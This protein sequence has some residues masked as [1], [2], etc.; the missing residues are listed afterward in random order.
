MRICTFDSHTHSFFSSDGNCSVENL[1]LTAEQKGL[2][3]FALTDHFECD[4]EGRS[5][6]S[7]RKSVESA[8]E[9][10]DKFKGRLIV[11]TGIELGQPIYALGEAEAALSCCDYDFVLASLHNIRGEP[12]FYYTDFSDKDTTHETLE[13]FFKEY[14]ELANWNRFDSVAHITYPFRYMIRTYN[15]RPSLK[16]YMGYVDEFLKVIIQNGKGIEINTS[17]L[18]QGL[19]ITMPELDC[20]KRFRELGGEI[21]TVGS[22]AHKASD[23]GAD[24]S[25]ATEMLK[26]AGF[27]RY[28]YFMEGKPHFIKLDD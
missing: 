7:I 20:I 6:D 16:E 5:L 1:C 9:Y 18:R 4:F 25:T 27:D 21:I 23:M 8:R 10:A 11:S 14:L 19:G 3:G 17:G 28:A 13:S 12:D 24:F 26:L 15:L 2:A 22:D